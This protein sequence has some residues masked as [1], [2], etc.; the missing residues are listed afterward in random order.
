[1]ENHIRLVVTS[2]HLSP[3]QIV[4]A[5]GVPGDKVWAFGDRRDNSEILETENGLI[6]N[7]RSESSSDIDFHIESIM[8][9]VDGMESN[10]MAFSEIPGCEIQLSCAVYCHG[11]PPLSFE[12]TITGWIGSMG[13]SLDIDIYLK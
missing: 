1:M 3:D 12:K 10:F 7:S 4:R 5:I 11:A 13:A 9:L 2:R 6:I 8:A